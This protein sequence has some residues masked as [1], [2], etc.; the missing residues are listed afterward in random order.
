MKGRILCPKCNH[1]FIAEAK[2][3]VQEMEVRCPQCNHRF[4]VKTVPECDLESS[5]ND[6]ECYWEEHGEPRKTILSSI[7]PRTDR[8]MIASVLLIIVVILGISSAIAP[9]FFIQTPLVV[10]STAGIND[11]IELIVHTQEE[12]PIENITISYGSINDITNK[13]GNARLQQVSLGQQTITIMGDSFEQDITIFVFPFTTSTYKISIDESPLN[14]TVSDP[15]TDLTWCSAVLII[16][17]IVTMLGAISSIRRRHSDVAI[18]CSLIGIFTIGFFFIGSIL[19]IVSF[20]LIIYSKEEF[21]D[22]KK[23]KSF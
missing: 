18:V 13:T 12:T 15:Q 9:A 19:S 11:T 5:K 20:L 14:V 4:N 6:E 21:D 3:D 1:E 10:L 8:P 16:L 17:S 7:K 2:P 23:G 22:G